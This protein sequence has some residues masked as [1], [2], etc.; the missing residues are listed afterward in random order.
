M[1]ASGQL[2]ATR[3]QI[4]KEVTAGT[5]V[6]A[7]RVMYFNPDGVLTRTRAPREH[8]FAVGRRDNVLAYTNG[9]IEAGG[10]VGLPMSS[11]EML[12]L[13]LISV[14]GSVTPT[15]PTGATAGRQWVFKPS[16]TVDSATV[17]WDDAA[18]QWRGL[19]VKGN[20]LSIQGAVGDTNMVTCDLFA[21]DVQ[22][23]ALT[24]A[25]AER[26]P[27]FMEGWQTLVYVDPFGTAPGTT[28]IPSFLR[29][30]QVQVGNQLGRLQ[31]AG[32]TLATNRIT[33][34]ELQ[35]SGSLT[36]D[37]NSAQAA[38]EFANWDAGTKRVVRLEFLG[39][40][41]EI[42]AAINEVQ[43]LTTT[44]T[45]TGGTFTLVV[46]G[47][48]TG[49]I[50]FNATAGAVATAINT[51]LAPLGSTYTVSTSGGPLP[52]GVPITFDGAGV[53]GRNIPPITIGTN[54]LTGGATPAPAI[55]Q[56]TAGYYGGRS[57]AVDIPG[58]WTSVAL[59]GS[60]DGVRTYDLALQSVYD[61]TNLAAM[62]AFTL[63]NSRATAY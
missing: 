36:V 62:I 21:T 56:T 48:V 47:Q 52:T 54:A 30:W 9:P 40:R 7:T 26:V 46:L 19:G 60:N 22:L 10:S 61:P 5:G 23:N 55:A 33:Q 42:E 43:T 32:N 35:V 39:P 51:A 25:L 57:V 18:R 31:L 4:G 58:A 38:T 29:N 14:Q 15:T 3:F 63:I 12:E 13:L 17:E 2:W 20:N 24:G 6:A 37:A 44:G 27:T 41:A 1:P 28:Q 53:A 8:R 34:G 50:A 11:E 49:T 59:G 45:P 16:P